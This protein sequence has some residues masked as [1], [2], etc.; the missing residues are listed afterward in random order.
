MSVSIESTGKEANSSPLCFDCRNKLDSRYFQ[1]ALRHPLVRSSRGK[2]LLI[3]E[4]SYQPGILSTGQSR[5]CALCV[6]VIDT[7]SEMEDTNG[8][9][10][11]EQWGR[12]WTS[13][14]WLAK[15]RSTG[16]EL[17]DV[18]E[19]EILLFDKTYGS[20]GE[21]FL[22]GRECIIIDVRVEAGK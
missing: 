10:W 12:E 7:V 13:G 15:C 20:L 17:L 1:T 2:S 5:N 19:L 18:E 16:E 9:D 4:Y 14:R 8:L 22:V 11:E 6:L 21:D 3:H